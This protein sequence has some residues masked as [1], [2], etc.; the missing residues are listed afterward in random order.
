MLGGKKLQ[1]LRT[2]LALAQLMRKK[3]VETIRKSV[4]ARSASKNNQSTH[5]SPTEFNNLN[6]QNNS[7]DLV[8]N[9]SP[10]DLLFAKEYLLKFEEAKE[11]KRKDE[12][13]MARLEQAMRS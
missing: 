8:L 12:Q 5:S 2:K 11:S 6:F 4:E 9:L 10:S 7:Q 3:D 13:M 1:S